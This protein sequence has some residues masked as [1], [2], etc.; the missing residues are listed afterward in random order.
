MA[1]GP[2]APPG[3]TPVRRL[4]LLAVDVETTGLDPGRDAIL[5]VGLVPVDG[6]RIELAGARRLVVR[7]DGD[8]G[9]SVAV[10]G[11]THDVLAVGQPL[12]RVL[13]E[14]FAALDGRALLAHHAALEEGF[15][16]AAARRSWGRAPDL[17]G[18]DT[19]ALQR[20][21][22]APRHGD[23]PPPGSLRLWAARRRFGLPDVPAHDA[24]SDALACAELYLAQVAELGARRELTL[25]DLRRA[26]GRRGPG[27]WPWGRRGA[28]G[29]E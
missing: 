12:E 8:V 4:R 24:L 6:L 13:A 5:A 29:R 20:R 7:H 2:A 21:L 17:R 16:G 9:S 23:E 27:R 14:V 19:L 25:D 26:R 10:H 15:L 1:R 28:P 22:L 11:L 3:G 18:V